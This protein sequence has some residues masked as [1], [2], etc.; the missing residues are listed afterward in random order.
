MC[1]K[2]WLDKPFAASADIQENLNDKQTVRDNG[3]KRKTFFTSLTA[4]TGFEGSWL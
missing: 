4:W 3:V 1:G 2:P